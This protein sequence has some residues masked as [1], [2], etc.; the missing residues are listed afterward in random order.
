MLTHLGTCDIYKKDYKSITQL[1]IN[2]TTITTNYAKDVVM[3]S[4]NAGLR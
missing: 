2:H 3:L 1:I 4:S